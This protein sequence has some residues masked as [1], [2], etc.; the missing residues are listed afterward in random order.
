M[1]EFNGYI[2]GVAE[3]HFNK[4]TR[5]IGRL[6]LLV[7]MLLVC[8]PLIICC[9]NIQNWLIVKICCFGFA[10]VTLITYIPKSEKK[11]KMFIPRKIFIQDD[12]ITCIADKYTETKFIKDVKKV[13]DYGEFYELIFPFGQI[14]E[15][16][17]CQKSLLSKGSLSD[18]ESLFEGKIKRVNQGTVL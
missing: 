17:I 5:V 11:Q 12:C 6:L 8:I 15:K 9:V 4:K 3:K 16:F 13:N 1:V 7:S 2:T 10:V 18:F 14:S